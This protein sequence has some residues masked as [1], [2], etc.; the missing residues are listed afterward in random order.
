MT[1]EDGHLWNAGDNPR[2]TTPPNS[3]PHNLCPSGPGFAGFA[4]PRTTLNQI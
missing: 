2:L 1:E 4:T 3:P